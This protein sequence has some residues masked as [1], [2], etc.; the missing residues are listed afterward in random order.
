MRPEPRI[1]PLQPTGNRPDIQ[2]ILD[3]ASNVTSGAENVYRTMATNAG[4]L[5]HYARFAAKVFAG[6][7]LP[8]PERELVILRTAVLCQS[9]YE[10]AHHNRIARDVGVLDLEIAAVLT[11]PAHPSWPT[12]LRA[13]LQ[14]TD[15]LVLHHTVAEGTW[16]EMAA[17]YDDAL[18]IELI[19]LIGNYVLL[20]GFLNATIVQ[21]EPAV[22]L[23][24]AELQAFAE[25]APNAQAAPDDRQA[26]PAT[27]QKVRMVDQAL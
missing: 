10:W 16:G 9:R 8:A 15:E 1:T 25:A 23:S 26:S 18:L 6:G 12:Q 17:L 5:R 14:F 4:M 24:P 19:L 7:K 2:E 22:A 27:D 3:A 11:G 13:L 20:A 21:L